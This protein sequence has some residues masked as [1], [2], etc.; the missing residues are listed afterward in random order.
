M[1]DQRLW[2]TSSSARPHQLA[3]RL[4]CG[5]YLLV[6]TRYSSAKFA[7]ERQKPWPCAM[8]VAASSSTIGRERRVMLRGALWE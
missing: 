7:A 8:H 5:M 2:R 6:S 3:E 4:K 1:P